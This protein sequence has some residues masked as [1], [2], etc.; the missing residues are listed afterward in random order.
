MGALARSLTFQVFRVIGNRTTY[1]GRLFGS[2]ML[3]AS[4]WSTYH[5]LTS[6][7]LSFLYTQQWYAVYFMLQLLWYKAMMFGFQ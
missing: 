3:L 1:F 5:Q 4:A 7:V 6:K 2:S